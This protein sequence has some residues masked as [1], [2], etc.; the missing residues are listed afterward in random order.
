MTLLIDTAVVPAHERLDFWLESS[1]HAYHP[2]QI[3]TPTKDAFWAQM[4]G[5]EVGS[6]G[7]FKIAAAAN[8]MIRTSQD[9][10]A[11]DPECLHFSVMLRGEL[12]AAQ[13]G[14]TT[15]VRSGD[16]FSYETSRP[17]ILRTDEPFESLVVS[18]PRGMLGRD[19]PQISSRTAVGIRER[20]GHATAAAS[21]V[22]RL[23]RRLE[24]GSFTPA[25]R[26]TTAEHM[27]D[28][29]RGLYTGPDWAHDRA[30][31]RSRAE[32]LL[33][34]ESF[35]ESN[36]GDPDLAPE[37]IARASFIS[38]RYLHK[39]FEAEGTSVCEW[40]RK[41][42]LERCRGDLLDPALR[43]QT[44]LAIASRWGLPS[45]QHFSRVFRTA[46]GY[47]PR[48]FRGQSRRSG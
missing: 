47:S 29:I 1:C 27:L 25:E 40:I 32:I 4:W 15:L 46:Y 23:A 39:L 14:R 44:I 22:R 36:L 37:G 6:I 21:F 19:A 9:I 30:R 20:N 45:A 35:I 38:S 31:S 43:H 3:R 17:T 18:L 48:E 41:T 7:V 12:N 24:D 26:A 13:E 5:Y 2:L 28:L 11:S 33:S 16:V 42:R 10:Q 34:V 8:T